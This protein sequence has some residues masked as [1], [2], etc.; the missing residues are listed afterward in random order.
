MPRAAIAGSEGFVLDCRDDVPRQVSQSDRFA[1]LLSTS[2][3]RP[4]DHRY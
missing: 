3:G 1:L 4:A 2:S